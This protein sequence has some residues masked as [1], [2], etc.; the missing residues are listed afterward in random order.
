[1][2]YMS[3]K[4]TDVRAVKG[5]SAFL[6]D[7]GKTAVLY[8]SGFG[9][10]GFKIAENIKRELKDRELDF[11]FLT[12][13]HY[14]HALGSAYVKSVYKDAKVVAGEYAKKI[15]AKPSA[16]ALMRELDA[17][18]ALKNGVES[19]EDLSSR[20]SVDIACK[21]GDKVC[22][23]DMC[24][25]ALELFGHTRCSVGYYL[26]D[27]SLLLSTESLGVY[28]G[29]SVVVPSYLVGYRMVL[30]SIR[31]VMSLKPEKILVPHFGVICGQ[32]AEEYLKAALESATA[33]AEEIAEIIRSGGTKDDA[34]A[35][36]V[37]KFYTD[38]VKEIY[39]YDAMMLNT[40]ISVDL[41]IK[42]L[43]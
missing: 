25:T 32:E 9:F 8:D 2:I 24:F 39:P 43:M 41:I 26:E 7:D 14:D 31:K 35:H 22:A 13:S 30:D 37:S 33:T 10:T 29:D 40:S 42:E 15:F 27:E 17:K 16:L 23:G 6:I 38:K 18:F 21:D 28:V 34:V 3:V 19:Y 1:M 36:F 12:H 11:I 5:D 20:L 4:I